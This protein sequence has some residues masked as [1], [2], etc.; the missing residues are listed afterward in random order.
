MR[1]KFIHKQGNQGAIGKIHVAQQFFAASGPQGHFFE[2]K[3]NKPVFTYGLGKC[4][5]QTSFFGWSGHRVQTDTPTNIYTSNTPAYVM[6]I[7]D[8]RTYK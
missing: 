7:F 5:Y 6:W 4:V 3:N 8:I 1:Y 2:K